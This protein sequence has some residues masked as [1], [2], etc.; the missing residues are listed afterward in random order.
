MPLAV[1]LHNHMGDNKLLV[2]GGLLAQPA[3]MYFEAKSVGY[4]WDFLRRW[5]NRTKDTQFDADEIELSKKITRIRR[6]EK[7]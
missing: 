1:I 3:A 6:G 2:D 7:V 4:V 5:E